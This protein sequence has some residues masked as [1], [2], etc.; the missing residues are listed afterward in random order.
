MLGNH[1]VLLT[2]TGAPSLYLEGRGVRKSA[3]KKWLSFPRKPRPFEKPDILHR[4]ED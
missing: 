3:Q 2:Y 1:E 4:E